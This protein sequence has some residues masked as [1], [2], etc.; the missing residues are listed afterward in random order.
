MKRSSQLARRTPLRRRKTRNS[1]LSAIRRWSAR[2]RCCAVC[3]LPNDVGWPQPCAHHIVKRSRRRVDEPWNL[4]WVC[5]LCH[6]VLEGERM[7]RNGRRLL[8]SFA[9]ALWCKRDANPE[10]FDRAKLAAAY[11]RPLPRLQKP[12]AVFFAER[13]KWD[14]EENWERAW[15]AVK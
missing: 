14:G 7:F 1:N 6:A 2:Q 10:E 13:A 4:L 5:G 15:E 8:L 9:N 11:G 3:H 12:P